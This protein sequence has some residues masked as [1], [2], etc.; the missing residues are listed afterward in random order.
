MG[1]RRACFN[2]L[3]RAG[4]RALR[5]TF[6]AGEIVL[7]DTTIGG[8][9]SLRKEGRAGNL[10]VTVTFRS[11]DLRDDALRILL[12]RQLYRILEVELE[13]GRDRRRRLL[14]QSSGRK[15][16]RQRANSKTE[17]RRRI[18]AI[19]IPPRQRNGRQSV[20]IIREKGTLLASAVQVL[21]CGCMAMA[22]SAPMRIAGKS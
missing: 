7:M 10:G 6:D 3:I 8:D 13:C 11:Q 17:N 22:T 18:A 20:G 16:N 4:G 1:K 14:R 9:T 2:D 19:R 5:Y 21:E 12:E 15:G